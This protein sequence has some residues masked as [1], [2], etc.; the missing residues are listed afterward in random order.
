[1]WPKLWPILY[2]SLIYP[3]SSINCV[4]FTGML[5]KPF[6]ILLL[7]FVGAYILRVMFLPQLALTFGYDQARDVV[8]A[9]QIAH[10]HLKILGPPSSTPGLYHGVFYYYVLAPAYLVGSGSPLIAAY[11]IAFLNSLTVF[12]IFAL[13]YLFFKKTGPALLASLFFA[14]SFEST[15][16]A[17]WLSNPTL[18]VWTVPLIYLGLWLWINSGRWKKWGSVIC[19]LG[20]GLSMQAEIFLLYHIV[21]VL[22]WLWFSK[23]QITR[24]EILRFGG[25]FLLAIS[26]M[27]LSEIKFGF[28]GISGISQ[29]LINQDPFIGAKGFGEILILYLNQ[30]GKVFSLSSYPG[31]LGYG[32]ILVLGLIIFYLIRNKNRGISW[33]A[34]LATWLFSHLAVVSIGGT[35]TPFLLVGIGP[36]VSILLGYTVYNLWRN[37]AKLPAAILFCVILFGN[38]SMIFKEN[39]K[40]QTIFSIQKEMT[41]ARQLPAIDYTYESAAGKPFSIYT[42]TSPY[43]INVVW[44]YL[45]HWYGQPKYGYLPEWQGPDQVGQLLPLPK[46]QKS[47]KLHYFISEPLDGI[48]GTLSGE[49]QDMENGT[50][51]LLDEAQFGFIKVQKREI[52][53]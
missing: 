18:G 7:I 31:N 46:A 42:L 34:F 10:G 35:S 12:T 49:A 36:T 8:N 32:A 44:S 11:W 26:T 27:L 41:L 14:I 51:L 30:L 48:K 38:L 22:I 17:V 1:M 45:Y 52:S 13:S 16:Y 9:F 19:G 33:Q 47:T 4:Y 53:I 37:D 40:G 2:S 3:K 21:P 28:R 15:Q 29:L 39:P 24:A 25:S 50:S 20:L 23:K 5:K 43:D 6:V